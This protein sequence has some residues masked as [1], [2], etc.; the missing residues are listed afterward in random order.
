MLT[1]YAD[2]HGLGDIEFGL[3]RVPADNIGDE[4]LRDVDAGDASDTQENVMVEIT[5]SEKRKAE[6]DMEVKRQRNGRKSAH[7][8]IASGLEKFGSTLGAAIIHAANV[9]NTPLNGAPDMTAQMAKLLEVAEST[10]ASI[11]SS[12]QVQTKLL[13]FL[14]SKF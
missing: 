11:E 3:E 9:K 10:K 5:R 6:V 1:A 12:N 8:D 7:A 4:T 13:A 2:L 14:E